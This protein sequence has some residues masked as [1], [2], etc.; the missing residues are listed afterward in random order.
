MYMIKKTVLIVDDDL[1][2]AK[3]MQQRLQADG[4]TAHVAAGGGATG[5]LLSA[6][7]CIREILKPARWDSMPKHPL[8]SYIR[9]HVT[10][11]SVKS[12]GSDLSIRSYPA[13]T[14]QSI[15][16]DVGPSLAPDNVESRQGLH[17]NVA[18]LTVRPD[19]RKQIA[20]LLDAGG[21]RSI[22]A[23]TDVAVY[24]HLVQEH[25]HAVVVDI[26]DVSLGGLSVLALCKHHNPPVPAYAICR[27]G[28]KAMRLSRDLS[29]SGYF[30]FTDNGM[31]QIDHSRGVAAT[32]SRSANKQKQP[33]RAS[34]LS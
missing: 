20:S 3:A 32:V 34:A 27:G 26:E 13:L 8:Q 11:H 14:W 15:Q 10:G 12:F 4:V 9:D 33:C 6:H 29:C 1:R 25:V 22:M 30:Y 2:E 17:G 24:Q 21:S 18:I 31:Q 19:I 16:H 5:K 28:G 23:D 7:P